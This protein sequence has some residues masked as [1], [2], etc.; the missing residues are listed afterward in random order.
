MHS[1]PA[2]LQEGRQQVLE[3][4]SDFIYL[5]LPSPSLTALGMSRLHSWPI[6]S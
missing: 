4:V 3:R 6:V 1:V 5:P 2:Q